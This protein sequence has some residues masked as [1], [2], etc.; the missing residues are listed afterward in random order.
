M[1]SPQKSCR[2]LRSRGDKLQLTFPWCMEPFGPKEECKR[3]ITAR[4]G[5][6]TS[7]RNHDTRDWKGWQLSMK[8]LN[9]SEVLRRPGDFWKLKVKWNPFM[10]C[11]VICDALLDVYHEKQRRNC[12]ELHVTSQRP[13]P[14][15]AHIVQR[16]KVA[17]VEDISPPKP[18]KWDSDEIKS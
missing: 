5:R 8:Q 16:V 6:R 18:S 2:S 11:D 7:A 15:N 9:Q 3:R 4:S 13:R 17:D 10:M 1:N 12:E 14:S